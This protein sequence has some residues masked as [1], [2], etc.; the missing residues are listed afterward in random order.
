MR[1]YSRLD[2]GTPSIA[3]EINWSCSIRGSSIKTLFPAS[4]LFLITAGS[5]E[6][7][8]LHSITTITI[9]TMAS[10]SPATTPS[11]MRA[12]KLNTFGQPYNLESNIPVPVLKDE[13]DLLIKVEAASFCHTDAILASGTYIYAGKL[14]LVG[15]HE[16]AG[17]VVQSMVPAFKPGARVGVP[18]RAYHPC[19]AC[20]QCLSGP[21][22]FV[23]GDAVG[24]SIYCPHSQ[25]HGMNKDG[26]FQEY[27]VVD[28]R[29]V[30]RLPDSLSFVQAAP[31]MCAGITI[32]QALKRCGLKP[33][34]AVGIVGCGGGLGHLGLLFAA[35]MGLRTMGVDAADGALALARS[36]ETDA[37]IVD[38]RTQS[39]ED[40]TVQFLEAA[41]ITNTT[42]ALDAVIILPESQKAFDYGVQ[43]LKTH[44]KCVVVSFP[45]SG[46]TFSGRDVVF[47]DISII[48]SLVGSN[49][50]LNEMVQFAAHHDVKASTKAYEFEELNKLVED[51]HRGV[52]SKLVLRVGQ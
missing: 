15:C 52:S 17:T 48:G 42:G 24:Y 40:A 22:D 47:R 30:A 50:T 9:I 49:R 20:E 41:G 1:G 4:Y 45:K 51:Y 33:G 7:L 38:S 8:F 31:L 18:G 13:H 5:A 44:G 29:Q 14:P 26:G 11:T 10:G 3:S 39:V 28:S 21:D 16:F 34:Q 37:V 23:S 6:Q 2:S 35:E 46:F 27:T 43:L 36:L 25:S 12:W 32:Y 19:G